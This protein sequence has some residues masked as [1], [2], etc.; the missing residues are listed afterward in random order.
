[1]LFK[2]NIIRQHATLVLLLAGWLS[3]F[4]LSAEQPDA[5]GAKP[6]KILAVGNSFTVNATHYLPKIAEASEEAKL[7]LTLATVGGGPLDQ[8]WR[9]V[10]AHEA[11]PEDLKGQIY[12]KQSL[13]EKLREQQW[14]FVTIQ[15]NSYKSTDVTTY[16]PYAGNL[17]AYIRKHAPGAELVIHQTWAYRAD[18]PRFA[19]NYSQ[20]DMYQDLTH[21]YRTIAKELSVEKIIPVGRAF[22]NARKDPRWNF[23]YP[24]PDFSYEQPVF[25]NVPR[26]EH[27]LNRGWNWNRD[28]QFRLDGHHANAAG[29]YLAAAVWFEFF[30]GSDVRGNDFVP[31][32]L[33]KEDVAFLQKI[34]H[35]AVKGRL[36]LGMQTQSNV[37]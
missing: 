1:M 4:Q 14:D 15:Q 17:A 28:K 31:T 16:R 22:Q 36:E 2:R 9:A 29:E 20:T 3:T 11:D 6:L 26:Q 24:D 30:F 8:H 12:R 7:A 32:E 10:V 5:T 37:N 25:P 18:D 27:S 35:D 21:A 23:V 13:K 33:S 19:E 34:A